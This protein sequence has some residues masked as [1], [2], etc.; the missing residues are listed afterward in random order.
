MMISSGISEIYSTQTQGAQKTFL[1]PVYDAGKVDPVFRVA[2]E[3]DGKA[4]YSKPTE[5]ERDRLLSAA[6]KTR[7]VS[8]YNSTGGIAHSSIGFKPGTFFDALA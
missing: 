4:Y 3:T 5:E 8:S 6:E 2:R 1:W 7:G